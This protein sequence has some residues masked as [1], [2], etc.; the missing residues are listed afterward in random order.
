MFL[1]CPI[2]FLLTWPKSSDEV[3][4]LFTFHHLL[5]AICSP[6]T[7][8]F[9]ICNLYHYIYLVKFDK[10]CWRASRHARIKESWPKSSETVNILKYS[11]IIYKRYY[12]RYFMMILT[13]SIYSAQVI[14]SHPECL[15]FIHK[16]ELKVW[17]IQIMRE[18]I[19]VIFLKQGK[20]GNW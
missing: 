19:H 11:F 2:T 18:I 14:V 7:Y 13:S 15:L 1:S 5:F 8:T 16:S 4:C 6:Y 10:T 9:N 3:L 12:L 17:K 20:T